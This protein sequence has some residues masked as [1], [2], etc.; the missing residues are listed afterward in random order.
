M[1]SCSTMFDSF[2]T[3]WTVAHPGSSAQGILQARILEWVASSFSRGS[4]QP[5]DQTCV[6]C[7]VGRFFT[8]WA[9]REAPLSISSCQLALWQVQISKATYTKTFLISPSPTP[10]S[11]HNHFTVFPHSLTFGNVPQPDIWEQLLYRVFCF[12]H[13]GF[14]PPLFCRT[15]STQSPRNFRAVTLRVHSAPVVLISYKLSAN[16]DKVTTA[17]SWNSH[18]LFTLHLSGS[19]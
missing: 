4:S 17:P 8:V 10:S 7:I 2:A 19:P 14:W 12:P 6:S 9:T 3:S 18:S 16:L 1:L 13:C 5:R 15:C 11:F